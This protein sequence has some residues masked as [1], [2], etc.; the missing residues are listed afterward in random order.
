[1]LGA[2]AEMAI[3]VVTKDCTALSDSDLAEM[4]DLAE[5]A[6]NEFGIGVLSKE[7][8]AWVLVTLAQRDAA[9]RVYVR[10]SPIRAHFHRSLP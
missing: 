8:E 1:M 3:H 4:G 2:L 10:T 7:A 9:L 5:V 6:G